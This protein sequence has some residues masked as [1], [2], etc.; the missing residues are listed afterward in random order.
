[1]TIQTYGFVPRVG[2][3]GRPDTSQGV[4]GA[5]AA[6]AEAATAHG[7]VLDEMDALYERG[8]PDA[9]F[10]SALV[11]TARAE[12]LREDAIL[13]LRTQLDDLFARGA[14]EAEIAEFRARVAA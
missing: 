7:D 3:L 13:S 14:S 8:A 11:R 9:S 1:M 5:K 4:D 6:I 12:Q 10:N 2:S